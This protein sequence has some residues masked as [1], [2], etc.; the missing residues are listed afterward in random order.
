MKTYT[1]PKVQAHP[2]RKGWLCIPSPGGGLVGWPGDSQPNIQA[3]HIDGPLLH[4]SDGQLHWLTLWERV[5]F[6]LSLTDAKKL[7]R[8]RRPNLAAGVG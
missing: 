3:N 7:Q 6:A 8:K 4:F 2:T 1:D 5:L